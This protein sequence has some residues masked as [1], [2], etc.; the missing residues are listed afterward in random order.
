MGVGGGGGGG[1]GVGRGG[2][3]CF[4]VTVHLIAELCP[5]A[6]FHKHFFLTFVKVSFLANSA[7]SYRTIKLELGK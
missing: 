4:E 7:N 6:N 1:R 3:Y 5:F 2:A